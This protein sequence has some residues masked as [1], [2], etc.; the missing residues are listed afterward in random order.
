MRRAAIEEQDRYMLERQRQFR[1][2]ADV[3]ADAWTR[4]REVA[5][6]AVIGSVAKP[7]WKEVPRFSEFRRARIE[8]WHECSDLDLA[9]WLDSQERLGELRRAAALALRKAF[10]KGTGISVADHQL[11]IF[12]IEPG[13]DNYLGRLCKFSQCPKGKI[14]CLVPGCGEIA[15]NKRVADF[16]P[17]DDLLAPAEG[18]MLYRRGVG[19]VRSAHD[20]PRTG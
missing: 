17:Y 5:A 20:L 4:F 12:L 3:V 14:D 8:V 1:A 18:G 6:V 2:A 7:L 19:R 9:L 16:T 11:D 10:E 13:T 15:F